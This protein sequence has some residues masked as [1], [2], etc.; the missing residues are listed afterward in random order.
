MGFCAA[1]CVLAIALTSVAPG[2]GIIAF[3]TGQSA[4][5]H[6]S[7]ELLALGIAAFFGPALTAARR[8][9]LASL[10]TAIPLG[11][12]GVALVLLP[13]AEPLAVPSSSWPS[14]R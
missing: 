2:I 9:R 7:G 4:T 12:L 14:P 3:A 6:L 8:L 5:A 1:L 10:T 13:F 11:Y